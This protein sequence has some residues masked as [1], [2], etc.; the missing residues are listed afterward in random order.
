MP[1]L[2]A[3]TKEAAVTY[4]TQITTYLASFTLAQVV[5]KASDLG[6][7]KD[8]CPEPES[9]STAGRRATPA[10]T[11]PS[12]RSAARRWEALLVI[13]IEY[14]DSSFPRGTPG[15]TEPDKCFNCREEGHQTADCP[16]PAVQEGGTPGGRL[17]RAHALRQVRRGG[18][19]EERLH[20]RGE[21]PPV[22]QRGRRD[23]GD[24]RPEG[25]RG[26]RGAVQPGHRCGINFSKYD[27]IPVSVTGD[28]KPSR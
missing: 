3:S 17:P 20:R 2:C 8:D 11:V 12:P 13:S 14:S 9:A 23:Q 10:R 18:P 16:E 6:H 27:K 4:A 22:H 24:V 1:A 7:V 5:L 28:N 21:D 26:R 19:H 25:R 15:T